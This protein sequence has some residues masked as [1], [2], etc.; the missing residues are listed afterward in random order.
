MDEPT[1]WQITLS[2]WPSSHPSRREKS[3]QVCL[4]SSTPWV[5]TDAASVAV[6]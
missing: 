6:N 2:T 1:W 4:P 3:R 5:S